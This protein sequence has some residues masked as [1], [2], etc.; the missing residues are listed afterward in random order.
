MA[1]SEL[2]TFAL[3]WQCLCVLSSMRLHQGM[4]QVAAVSHTG[5]VSHEGSREGL[6]HLDLGNKSRSLRANVCKSLREWK[7]G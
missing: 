1:R 5:Q 6:G 2:A 7:W 4:G 3:R